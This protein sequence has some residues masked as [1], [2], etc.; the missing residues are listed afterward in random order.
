MHSHTSWHTGDPR[1]VDMKMP[2]NIQEEMG[3]IGERR[4]VKPLESNLSQNM[5]V[6][7]EED[8]GDLCFFM[9]HRL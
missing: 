7:S 4:E 3:E 8:R 9:H 6:N 1:P 5:I 2:T